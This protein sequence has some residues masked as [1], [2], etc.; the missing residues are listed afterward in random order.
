MNAQ[1]YRNIRYI[2]YVQFFKVLIIYR[3]LYEYYRYFQEG[4]NQEEVTD[5]I[6][7]KEKTASRPK[8]FL[9]QTAPGSNTPKSQAASGF[10]SDL[11]ANSCHIYLYFYRH[12]YYHPKL[13]RF[14]QQD[15]MG[16]EDS[17]NLYQAFNQNPVNFD[18]PMGLEKIDLV[19]A[20]KPEYVPRI[21]EKGLS[22]EKVK[23]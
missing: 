16:Y 18:D 13:G 19:H 8:N 7:V 20:T 9:I 14:L 11:A 2:R 10:N 4:N 6:E 22:S 17:L 23:K 1:V 15:P 3:Y 5:Q 21:L 12:R